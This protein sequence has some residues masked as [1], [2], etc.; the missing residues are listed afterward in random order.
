MSYDA[1]WQE[2]TARLSRVL[3]EIHDQLDEARATLRHR[4]GQVIT[5]RASMWEDLPHQIQDFEDLIEMTQNQI[6]LDAQ[7]REYRQA[8]A[9]VR[10]LEKMAYSPYFGRIDFLEEGAAR[11]EE[12]YIG[13]AS[14]TDQ[15]RGEHLVSTSGCHDCHTPF[16]VGPNGPEPDMA[17]ALSGHPEGMELP[18]PPAAVGPWT[19]AVTAT[20]TAWSGPWGVSFTANLTPDRE[21]GLGEW[22]RDDFIQTIRTARH[23][24]RGRL[25][26]PPMPVAAYDHFSDEELEAIFAYL[27]SLPALKNRVPDPIAPATP[28]VQG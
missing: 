26:L 9:K 4:K 23:R 2:E 1:T 15:A 19:I 10:R 14:L 21:T 18:P 11:P 22:T 6:L 12:I 13:I 28:P 27:Q 25:L 24:G 8:A 7:E 5:A 17:R 3:A 20:N 16:K